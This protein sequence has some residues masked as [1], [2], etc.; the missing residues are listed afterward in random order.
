MTKGISNLQ[1][2]AK[3]VLSFMQIVVTIIKCI[4]TINKNAS[5]SSRNWQITAI[6]VV[7]N[8]TIERNCWFDSLVQ[9]LLIS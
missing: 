7:E 3:S 4:A 5:H 1:N 6:Y 2:L 9:N 8:P